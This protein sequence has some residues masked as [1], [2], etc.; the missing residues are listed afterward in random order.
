[1]VIADVEEFELLVQTSCD[2]SVSDR[3]IAHSARRFLERIKAGLL[4]EQA[5]VYPYV[6]NWKGVAVSNNKLVCTSQAE[7][8]N[9]IIKA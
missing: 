4:L 1:M 5:W 6:G 3:V 7:I 9:R 2:D 8:L